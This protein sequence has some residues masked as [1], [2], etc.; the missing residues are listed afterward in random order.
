MDSYEVAVREVQRYCRVKIFE[1]LAEAVGQSCEP[2]RLHSHGEVLAFNV[3]RTDKIGIGV[4]NNAMFVCTHY[5]GR[6]VPLGSNGFGF[7][8]LDDLAVVHVG[9]EVCLCGFYVRSQAVGRKLYP[10]A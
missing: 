3:G 2:A 7:V 5:F 6:A 8:G 9:T 10:I 4:T 1:F